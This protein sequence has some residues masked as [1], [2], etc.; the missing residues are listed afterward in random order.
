MPDLFQGQ[1]LNIKGPWYIGPTRYTENEVWDKITMDFITKQPKR[2]QDSIRNGSLMIVSYQGP[3]SLL[4]NKGDRFAEK[5]TRL[6][7]KE[8]LSA[9]ALKLHLSQ[10]YG[11]K[12][13]SQPVVGD[14]VGE[15]QTHRPK[16]IHETTDK[17]FK[18][19]DSHAKARS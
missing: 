11:R 17:I 10:L 12:C 3:S 1:G 7:M 14:I 9:R 19:I 13:L 2:Q 5:L 6:Y 4:A 18:I 8:K 15:A 16:I